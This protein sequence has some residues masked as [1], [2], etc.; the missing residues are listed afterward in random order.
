MFVEAESTNF[1]KH[2]IKR[3]D[4]N[5]IDHARSR[6]EKL[7][8]TLEQELEKTKNKTKKLVTVFAGRQGAP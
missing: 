7:N 4:F 5:F 3:P 1:L 8:R 2:G 6:P